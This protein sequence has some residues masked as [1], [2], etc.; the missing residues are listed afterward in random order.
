MNQNEKS[1]Q[2]KGELP[3]SKRRS[4]SHDKRLHL[5]DLKCDVVVVHLVVAHGDVHVQR[6]V[7]AVLCQHALVRVRRFLEGAAGVR[8][9]QQGICEDTRL[10]PTLRSQKTGILWAYKPAPLLPS[11]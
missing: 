8:I 1:E 2:E 11:L 7:L 9:E 10:E 5:E 4:Q 6:P 3:L